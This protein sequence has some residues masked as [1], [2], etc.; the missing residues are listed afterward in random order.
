ML[1]N[2]V[3]LNQIT[4]RAVSKIRRITEV[5]FPL[6]LLAV[7]DTYLIKHIAGIYFDCRN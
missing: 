4:K 5:I 6:Y 2:S 3:E 1:L 7:L